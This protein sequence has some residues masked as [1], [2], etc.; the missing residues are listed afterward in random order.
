MLNRLKLF[1]KSIL[2]ILRITGSGIQVKG[3]NVYFAGRPKKSKKNSVTISGNDIYIGTRCHF[4]ANVTI[5]GCKVLIASNV[6]FVG[7]DHRTNI[8]GVPI[9]D[10]GREELRTVIISSDTWIGHGAIILHGV[11]IGEGSVVAAG[12]VVTKDVPPYIIVGGNPAKIIK[13]RFDYEE[14]CEHERRLPEVF[15]R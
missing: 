12:A 9:F 8:V 5:S 4:G 14:R 7:G 10:S 13:K 1:I 3:R 15:R 11:S 6:S 2:N